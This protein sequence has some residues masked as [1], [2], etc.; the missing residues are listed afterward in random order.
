MLFK[1]TY[2]F[3]VSKNKDVLTQHLKDVSKTDIPEGDHSYSVEFSWDEFIITSKAKM[4]S[5]KSFS[6]DAYLRLNSLSE[7]M[8]QVDVKIKFSE[9]TWMYLLFIQL[10]IICSCLFGADFNWW[11]RIGA[12]IGISGIW[13]FII[14]VTLKWESQ[15]LKKVVSKLFKLVE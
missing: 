6:A 5:R 2:R 14:W 10:G 13:N 15:A 1:E 9:I 12:L 4:F 7:D 8:T 3:Q 11:L